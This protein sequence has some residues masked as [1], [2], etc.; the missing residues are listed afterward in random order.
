M[1]SAADVRDIMGMAPQDNTVTKVPLLMI[2]LFVN[3]FPFSI[4]LNYWVKQK[5]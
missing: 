3:F 1:A 4:G 2:T 5:V